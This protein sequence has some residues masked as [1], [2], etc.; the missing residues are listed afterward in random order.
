MIKVDN[1]Y[2]DKIGIEGC[3]IRECVIIEALEGLE[4]SSNACLVYNINQA[5]LVLDALQQAIKKAKGK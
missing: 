3:S 2:G 4:S 1:E 5:E